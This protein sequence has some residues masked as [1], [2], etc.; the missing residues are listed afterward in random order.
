MYHAVVTASSS[1]A[2]ALAGLFQVEDVPE[3]GTAGVAGDAADRA[4]AMLREHPAAI[5]HF[6]LPGRPPVHALLPTG[7]SPLCDALVA[8]SGQR[9]YSHQAQA[10]ALA[11]EGKSFVLATPTASGKTLSFQLAV[12]ERIS[13]VRGGTAL[14]IYPMKALEHDQ[15]ASF[16]DL[17]RTL[18][19]D[20][21]VACY[22]GDVDRSLREDIRAR[23]RVVL[24]N[25]AMLHLVLPWHEKW[26][27]FFSKLQVVV[28]DE[29]HLHSGI[30]GAHAAYVLRRIQRV[31]RF[32]GADPLFV[33]AS[34]TIA[35]PAEH[36][37]ALCGKEVVA[38]TNSGA[39]SPVRHVVV[40]DATQ[41]S[42]SFTK[43]CLEPLRVLRSVG[44][45]GIAFGSSRHMVE[46]LSH[47]A[48]SEF[49]KSVAAYRSGYD[50][51]DRRLLEHDLRTGKLQFVIS[52]NALEVGIDIG[53]LDAVIIAGYPG[54][55][56]SLR[57]QAGRVGRAGRSGTIVVVLG[58]DPVSRYLAA[59]PSLLFEGEVEHAT[60][61]LENPGIARKHLRCTAEEVPL[62]V[63]ELQQFSPVAIPVAQQA[64]RDEVLKLRPDRALA[65][66]VKTR[67]GFARSFRVI[68]RSEEQVRVLAAP[69]AGGHGQPRLL[70]ELEYSRALKEVYPGA[71]YRF[72]GRQYR[73]SSL[74]LKSKTA[75]V[76]SHPDQYASTEPMIAKHLE[77]GDDYDDFAAAGLRLRRSAVSMMVMTV[78]YR[79]TTRDRTAGNSPLVSNV[80]L[81]PLT[82]AFRTIGTEIRFPGC[83]KE[84]VHVI[85]HL[86]AKVAPVV[87]GCGSR[88]VETT[89]GGDS[90][91]VIDAN[92]GGSGIAEQILEACGNVLEMALHLLHGCPCEGLGCPRCV[93]QHGCEEDL[94]HIDRDAVAQVLRRAIA[95]VPGLVAVEAAEAPEAE[96]AQPA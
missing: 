51:K 81:S 72:Q 92:E 27:R 85:E 24:S 49:G 6:D 78:G 45:Q 37:S 16:R 63:D 47:E 4:Y 25:V 15:L 82:Y 7:V 76:S 34:A 80:S 39:P 54:S 84:L 87:V 18:G 89:T 31:A 1:P 74:D 44:A 41:G 17:E 58:D 86:V 14:C 96:S 55:L 52:T 19:L 2:D 67:G 12:L 13:R 40:L 59:C 43:F 33:F 50:A 22:D 83:D 8:L 38:V 65:T 29:A 10:L 73:V 93:L 66:E 69:D 70:E 5:A 75:R 90:M 28:V 71:I 88:D 95:A 3:V 77:A 57:Q 53:G 61:A 35:N 32:Y 36:A 79:L 21:G 64:A 60:V 62:P 11:A 30:A 26:R 42:T 91:W 56:S 46:Y 94:R 23:S 20:L 68:G 9:P 48:I